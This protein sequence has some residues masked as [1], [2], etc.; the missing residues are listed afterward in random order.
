[1]PF[2][3][4]TKKTGAICWKDLGARKHLHFQNLGTMVKASL[5]IPWTCFK[6]GG[7]V[8]RFVEVRAMH[9]FSWLLGPAS[10]SSEKFSKTCPP[11]LPY[12]PP[13]GQS[14]IYQPL[15]GPEP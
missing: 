5:G 2:N 9:Y 14:T 11:E 1:M 8:P 7:F 4:P 3:K 15:L 10:F 12:L 6:M 13:V